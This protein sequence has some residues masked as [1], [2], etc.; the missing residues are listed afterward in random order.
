MAGFSREESYGTSFTKLS[1]EQ[2]TEILK[3][4]AQRDA[5]GHAFFRLIR[6]YTVM[7]YYTSAS[8]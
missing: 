6:R 3:R 4:A 1:P 8:D 5:D 7:G 2:Q